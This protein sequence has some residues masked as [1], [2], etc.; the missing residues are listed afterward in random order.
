MKV[1]YRT[2]EMLT[3][4]KDDAMSEKGAKKRINKKEPAS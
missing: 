1:K 2:W 3:Y 4:A